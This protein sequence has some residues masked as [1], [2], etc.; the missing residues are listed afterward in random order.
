MSV[1]RGVCSRVSAR[2][3]DPARPRSS[4][5]LVAPDRSAETGDTHNY[6]CCI[7]GWTRIAPNLR[8]MDMPNHATPE[9]PLAI[10]L[11]LQDIRV[12]TVRRDR[13]ILQRCP[14]AVI[15]DSFTVVLQDH[16]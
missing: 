10:L 1:Q 11:T 8:R 2:P 6:V 9:T 13:T 7:R 16:I 14:I 15:H 4:A 12:S 5:L 3:Q